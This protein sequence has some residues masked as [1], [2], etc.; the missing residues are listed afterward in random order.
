MQRR[1]ADAEALHGNMEQRD[2]DNTLLKFSNG[3]LPILVAT[4]VA[5][6]GIDVEGL[7]M[8]IISEL[9]KDPKSHVHRIGRTGRAGEKGLAFS[10]VTPRERMRLER[11]ESYL[12][13]EIPEAQ[14]PPR[15]SGG[16]G[17]TLAPNRTLLIHAGKR[18][19]IRKGDILGALIKDGGIPNEAIGKIELQ[20]DFVRSPLEGSMLPKRINI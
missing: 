8:V 3:S 1:G 2:R 18:D 6:R 12:D 15:S 20:P 14:L 4:N 9:S 16:L 11:I 5:A 19:K 13:A 17:F 10:I 7:P